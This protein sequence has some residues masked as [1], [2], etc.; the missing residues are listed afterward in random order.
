MLK[1]EIKWNHIKYSVKPEKA[2]KED[3]GN[4]QKELQTWLILI[5][6]Y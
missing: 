3:S 2:G 5:Q 6:I 1:E 4:N